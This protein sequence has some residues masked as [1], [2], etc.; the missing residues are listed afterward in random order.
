MANRM[1]V[2]QKKTSKMLNMSSIT[3]EILELSITTLSHLSNKTLDKKLKYYEI[4]FHYI[5]G[6]KKEINIYGNRAP[7][8]YSSVCIVCLVFIIVSLF[9]R[10][11]EI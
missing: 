2:G 5:S 3:S 11:K 6:R 10:W 4:T 1:H 8:I 7:S 9:F